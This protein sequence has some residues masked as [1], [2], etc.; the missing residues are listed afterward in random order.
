MQQVT[1]PRLVG[2]RESADQLL[3][4]LSPQARHERVVL[5]CRELLAASPSF[6]DEIVKLVLVEGRAS[7]LVVLGAD[8]EFVSYIRQSA[9]AHHVTSQV[10]IRPAG[11]EID[12]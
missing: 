3:E 2:S 12:A 5:N 4:S 10:A 7:E 9:E 11:S 1:L 8:D 6:A